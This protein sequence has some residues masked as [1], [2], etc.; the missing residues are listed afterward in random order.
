MI[1]KGV[2]RRFAEKIWRE[3]RLVWD[4]NIEQKA[5]DWLRTTHEDEETSGYFEKKEQTFGAPR[6]SEYLKNENIGSKTE[7]KK[8]FNL[9]KYLEARETTTTDITVAEQ[10]LLDKYRDLEI[11]H[12][13]TGLTS[14]QEAMEKLDE[15]IN[16]AQKAADTAKV[17]SLEQE[18]K[19]L[20]D[21][22]IRERGGTM[23]AYKI[24]AEGDRVKEQKKEEREGLQDGLMDGVKGALGFCKENWDK[25]EGNDKLI[26]AIGAIVGVVMLSNAKSEA[27]TKLKN[28]LWGGTKLVAG[29]VVVNT[30]LKIPTG[31]TGMQW[32]DEAG[33]EAFS[34][35]EKLKKHLKTD[36]EGI[37]SVTKSLVFMDRI[38]APLC[39]NSY[40]EAKDI[41]EDA[42]QDAGVDNYRA[43][44]GKNKDVFS[45]MPK[46]DGMKPWEV[47]SAMHAF[48]D[49]YDPDELTEDYATDLDNLSFTALFGMALA[50]DERLGANGLKTMF[51]GMFDVMKKSLGWVGDI[52]MTGAK[53][54]GDKAV[55]V[56]KGFETEIKTVGGG[57]V[58]TLKIGGTIV[59]GAPIKGAEL[60][61]WFKSEKFDE[62]VGNKKVMDKLSESGAGNVDK[63]NDFV[64]N[65]TNNP[66]G[67]FRDDFENAHNDPNKLYE[68]PT[69][70]VAYAVGEADVS[71]GNMKD[72]LAIAFEKARESMKTKYVPGT[73]PD[74]KYEEIVGGCLDNT[75]SPP[76]YYVFAR[77]PL[78]VTAEYSAREANEWKGGRALEMK[79]KDL[80]EAGPIFDPTT[81]E[82]EAEMNEIMFKYSITNRADF[83]KI[84][85]YYVTHYAGKGYELSKKMKEKWRLGRMWQELKAWA[86]D[87]PRWKNVGIQERMKGESLNGTRKT[88]IAAEVGLTAVPNANRHAAEASMKRFN[89][90][91]EFVKEKYHKDAILGEKEAN[92][93]WD[94]PL[95]RKTRYAKL[96]DTMANPANKV[97][98]ETTYIAAILTAL[99]KELP[100]AGGYTDLEKEYREFET[101]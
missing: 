4:D 15:E 80:F 74:L 33:K 63:I 75:Q 29:A 23:T 95:K 66:L 47:F 42:R 58:D 52:G 68:N 86:D 101:K 55:G 49:R 6:L 91:F 24:V 84:E 99:N 8:N 87:D 11:D 5:Q 97:S 22:L 37:Q 73:M 78:P 13:W 34:A 17:T 94:S 50:D 30:L 89:K 20:V 98:N 83:V 62:W 9:R 92:V 53:W 69:Q 1:L 93:F 21:Y 46:V 41:I 2:H 3:S 61:S 60:V 79:D 25:L 10:E 85:D 65:K 26:A 100:S 90:L 14:M 56:Y 57:V 88:A 67:N 59:L 18:K 72:A 76:K 96:L 19:D 48:F 43:L 35:D 40:I 71:G 7:F 70:H 81:V 45:L 31:K 27:M 38:K 82:G 64:T 12:S 39:I 32:L 16:E 28:Y 36:E 51:G 44:Y 77:M 54:V